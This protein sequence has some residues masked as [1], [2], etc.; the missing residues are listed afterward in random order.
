M[1]TSVVQLVEKELAGETVVL[2]ENLSECHF[3]H[4][5]FHMIW[6]DVEPWPPLWEPSY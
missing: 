2:G 1:V 3:V 5:K 4:H 6:P